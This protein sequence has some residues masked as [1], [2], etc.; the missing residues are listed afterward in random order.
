MYFC[1]LL[2]TYEQGASLNTTRTTSVE[3]SSADAVSTPLPDYLGKGG[4]WIHLYNLF[5]DWNAT[6]PIPPNIPYRR[7]PQCSADYSSYINN[8]INKTD[9]E[10][11]VQTMTREIG[12]CGPKCMLRFWDV[13]V[14][15]FPTPKSNESCLAHVSY[16]LTHVTMG[17]FPDHRTAKNTGNIEIPFPTE[18]PASTITPRALQPREGESI[19]VDSKGF[20]L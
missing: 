7:S 4:E 16:N 14:Y 11:V 1:R 2:L 15:Y 10:G 8:N 3:T 9:S 20:T 18:A 12:C 19:F 6:D 13:N 17:T 5:S